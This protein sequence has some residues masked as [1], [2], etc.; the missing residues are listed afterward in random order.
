MPRAR[1]ERRVTWEDLGDGVNRTHLLDAD[2]Q[3]KT[4]ARCWRRFSSRALRHLGGCCSWSCQFCCPVLFMTQPKALPL[5]VPG[6]RPMKNRGQVLGYLWKLCAGVDLTPA[7]LSKIQNW[8][9]RLFFIEEVERGLAMQYVSEKSDGSNVLASM[10]RGR[11]RKRPT[12]GLSDLEELPPALVEPVNSDTRYSMLNSLKQYEIAFFGTAAM[13][14]ASLPEQLFPMALNWID[15][16]GSE[17]RL[18]IATSQESDR[19]AWLVCIRNL[20]L[21]D[22]PHRSPGSWSR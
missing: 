8:R 9:R 21:M 20:W 3:L 6:E 11:T 12:T 15:A 1:L 2:G 13:H 10:I 16:S 4:W 18:V 14:V 7:N 17:Q 5:A 22:G 19:Q